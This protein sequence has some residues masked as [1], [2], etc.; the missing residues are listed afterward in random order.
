MLAL[1]L[2]C[3]SSEKKVATYEEI[4]NE[5]SISDDKKAI[6]ELRKEIPDEIKKSNDRLAEV[7]NRW[8]KVKTDPYALRE[9]FDD[10]I[11]KMRNDM[12]KKWRRMREDFNNRQSAMRKNFQRKQ[13]EQRDSF[14]SSKPDSD[15]RTEF[16]SEQSEMRDRFNSDLRDERDEFEDDLREARK[17]F[18]SEIANK[19][20]EFNQEFPEYQRIY[21][22]MK[23]SEEREK[24]ERQENPQ[25]YSGWPY[26]PEEA[27]RKTGKPVSPENVDVNKGGN[28]W[29]SSDPNEFN[30]MPDPNKLGP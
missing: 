19:R 29:P 28:G 3:S 22:E 1:L 8:K 4:K 24:L 7:L 25:P 5:E 16:T 23:L 26:D 9:K 6:E 20:T 21:K 11:R 10:E 13:K 14:Y 12:E 15:R 30:D 27:A 17:D 18:E 2:S